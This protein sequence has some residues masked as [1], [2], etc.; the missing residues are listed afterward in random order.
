M[1][2][3]FAILIGSLILV[4]RFANGQI[5]RKSLLLTACFVFY[6][7]WDWRLALILAGFILLNFA[8]SLTLGNR[9][10][11][12]GRKFLFILSLVSNLVFL[13]LFKYFNF[14]IDGL[15]LLLAPISSQLQTLNLI[16]PLGISFYTFGSI[17]Y[18]IDIYGETIKPNRSLLDYALFISFFPRIISGPIQRAADFFSQLD[19]GIDI[20]LSNL[21]EGT[22][23]ILRGMLKKLVIA[24]NLG[25]MTNNIYASPNIFSSSSTWVAVLAYSI[26]ILFDFSGYTDMAIGIAKIL[27]INLPQNFNLPYTSQSI[28]EFWRRW[29]MTLSS[30]FRD[31]L[32]YPL[33]ISRAR[34]SRPP[35]FQYFNILFVF[36]LTGLWHGANWN[37][38]LWGGLHGAYISIE[39]LLFRSKIKPQPWTSM[40]AWIRSL[41]IFLVL[42]LTWIPF[43]SPDWQTTRI[44]FEKLMF[45]K[46]TYNIEWY[47]I[48]A[49]ISIP[50]ILFGGFLVRRFEW[51]WPVLPIQKPYTPAF[52]LLEALLVFFFSP[53][54]SSPFIYFQF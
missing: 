37:F 17:S 6:S 31:Y 24:D 28:T 10:T 51:K 14:F 39:H 1:S 15:N 54:N 2:V 52:L 30:W 22:Q 53:I 11:I 20:T 41:L 18:I 5:F 34:K 44:I 19:K 48:W 38:V 40:K 26:Q 8:L 27:G 47:Y 3:P 9:K 42:T 50:I 45:I 16:L 35:L 23:L 7:F 49:L 12:I 29:H 25:I 13:G 32:F 4:V 21:N 36:L 46:S 33:E 43:R